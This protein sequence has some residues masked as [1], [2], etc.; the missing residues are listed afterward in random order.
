MCQISYVPIEGIP[1]EPAAQAVELPDGKL[2]PPDVTEWD[3]GQ[4][5][6]WQEHQCRVFLL[7]FAKES[8]RKVVIHPGESQILKQ[9]NVSQNSL[10]H[11]QNG[12]L[13]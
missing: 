13:D 2:L 5:H 10:F 1:S 8:S 4:N 6:R 12:K 7:H 3:W 11:N 9:T